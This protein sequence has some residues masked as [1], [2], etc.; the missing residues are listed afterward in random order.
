LPFDPTRLDQLE[1]AWDAVHEALPVGWRVGLPS[2]SPED[3]GWTVSAVNERTTCRGKHPQTVTGTGEAEIASLRDLDDRLR[4]VDQPDG[5]RM[6]ALRARLRLAYVE[7]AEDWAQTT[8]H[9]QLSADELGRI[10]ERSRTESGS[11]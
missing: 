4:G 2:Y 6:D 3:H 8:L 11:Q 7:G 1:A 5:S 9:R 10:I